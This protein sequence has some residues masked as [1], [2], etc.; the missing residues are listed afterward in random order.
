MAS[1]FRS[2][3]RCL[4]PALA[5]AAFLSSAAWAGPVATRAVLDAMIEVGASK[6]TFESYP[7]A[8]ASFVTVGSSLS[9]T[10]TPNGQ[11][12]GL[13]APGVTLSTSN[14]DVL[15]QGANYFNLPTKTIG[16]TPGTD[17]I[18]DFTVFTNAVGVDLLNYGGYR[19]TYDVTVFGLDDT[20]TLQS[21]TGINFPEAATPTFFGFEHAAGVGRLSVVAVAGF[22]PVIDNLTFGTVPE[23]ASLALVGL[24]LLVLRVTR[25]V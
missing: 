23:P 8:A 12:A 11:S 2:P 24:S 4:L 22:G 5:T 20:T 15:W 25:R 16:A 21:F 7:V 6:E 14:G 9:S 19:A 17:I 3:L 1:C 13:I 18:I 10:S